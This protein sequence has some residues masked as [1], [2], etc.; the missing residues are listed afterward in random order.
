MW[1]HHMLQFW[2]VSVIPL[3]AVMGVVVNVTSLFVL[4]SHALDMK[5]AFRLVKLSQRVF[6]TN[7][8]F[9]IPIYL[10]LDSVNI[11]KSFWFMLKIRVFLQNCKT[12]I[13]A[14]IGRQMAVKK[15]F[16]NMLNGVPG[17]YRHDQAIGIKL[18]SSLCQL[19]VVV[20][21]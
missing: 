13:Y 1:L 9:L 14:T 20:V 17:H 18:M 6:A 10:Q 12:Y 3:L 4:K 11:H 16:V 8:N 2:F 5:L 7:S 21:V 15:P 19:V